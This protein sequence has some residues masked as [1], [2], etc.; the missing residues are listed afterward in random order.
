ESA[1]VIA[2]VDG[3]NE[4][5]LTVRK[6]P[7]RFTP[8]FFTG[9]SWSPDGKLIAATVASSPRVCNVVVFSVAGG[10]EE[11]LTREPWVFASR[12][13]WL[14]DMSG[15]L[16]IG[17]DGVNNSQHWV[18]S[19]PGG[20]RRRV[21]NDLSAY[22]VISLTGDGRKIATIQVD[23]LINLW[24]APEGDATRAVRMPTGNVGFYA[25]GGNN[26][27]WTTDNRVVYMSNEGGVPD[28][29]IADPSEGSRRQLTTNG[30]GSPVAT[31]DGKYIV[32]VS[33]RNGKL[34]IWR[35]NLDGSNPVNLSNGPADIYPSVTPDG[36]WVVFIK[37]EGSKPTVWKVSIDGG[38][39]EQ[40]TDHVASSAIVSPDG[41]LLAYSYPESPDPFAPPNRLVV[42]NFADNSPVA[43][44]TFGPSSTVPTLIQWSPDGKSILYSV[45]RDSVSN[46]WSQPLSGGAPKQITEFK[47][48]LMTGFAW[49]RDGKMFAATRGSLLRDA[50]LITD[51][52]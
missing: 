48:G 50:V 10:K 25:S 24:V 44:F 9:P 37:S 27:S 20:E 2:N 18:L 11:V 51:L 21:T 42:V 28:V 14:P 17:G 40:V 52:R 33:G 22:R 6:R 15:L 34:A 16:V 46:V 38:T 13:E 49:S 36:Q 41:K 35:M 32:F 26:L 47:D 29:W 45:N 31:V 12:V 39:P 43:T 5:I 19:Y 4:Q 1:L 23:G 3:S 30:G 8:L 7:D